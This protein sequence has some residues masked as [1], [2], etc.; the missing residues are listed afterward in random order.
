M[1][2]D[3]CV[4]IAFTR[5]YG[6]RGSVAET[7]RSL[8]RQ[9]LQAWHWNVDADVP[10]DDP[11]IRPERPAGVPTY[12][13]AIDI[14]AELPPTMLEKRVWY[15]ETHPEVDATH[16]AGVTVCRATPTESVSGTSAEE[17]GDRL[18][19]R[20]AVVAVDVDADEPEFPVSRTGRLAHLPAAWIPE[21][22]PFTNGL[23]KTGPRL[24]LFVPWMEVGGADR[25]NLDLLATTREHGWTATVV[26]TLPGRQPWR[27]RFEGLT[28]DVFS[29]PNL[30]PLIDQPRFL[31]YLIGSRRPDVVLIANSEL[32]YR[33]LPYLRSTA[34][35][36]TFADY[37]HSDI[38]WWNSGGYPR[39]SVQFHEQ[40]DLTMTASEHLRNWMVDRGADPDRIEVAYVG[41]DVEHFCPDPQARHRMRREL[42]LHDGKPTVL[43]VGRLDSDKQPGVLIEA[44]RVLATRGVEFEAV[45]GGDGPALT[46]LRSLIRSHGLAD[47]IRLLGAV[48]PESVADL[49]RA[50][51]VLVLLSKW[52]GIAL[53]LYEAMACGLPVVAT[54]VGGHRELVTPPCGILI[55][56]STPAAEARAAAAALA[57]LLRDGSRR[58]QMGEAARARISQSFRAEKTKGRVLELLGE[59]QRL[60]VR[61]QRPAVPQGLAIATVT[62]AVEL[63]RIQAAFA[64]GVRYLEAAGFSARVRVALLVAVQRRLGGFYRWGLAHGFGF[65]T[66]AKEAIVRRLLPSDSS[67]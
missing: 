43:F 56:P 58:A 4:L 44:L 49:M 30:I 28:P 35:D 39:L 19:V 21:H 53:T 5:A 11:R 45:I 46:G 47:R 48:D 59:A 34:S 55:P 27:T 63:L 23:A 25:F 9:T 42:D 38:A 31:R 67:R 16:D 61:D 62:D 3:E 22:L 33:F 54:D 24:L 52:E 18:R 10:S 26:T 29:L 6:D 7:T 41:V 64:P 50:S 2:D 13:A 57:E 36:V 15:L 14:G 60:H 51:D 20:G 32:A 37:C 66:T 17:L 1:S 65:L 40:L 12:A 8:L